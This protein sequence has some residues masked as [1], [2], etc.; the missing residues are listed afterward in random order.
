MP[1]LLLQSDDHRTV[2]DECHLD[3]DTVDDREGGARLLAR[4]GR[5]IRE[6]EHSRER[7]E[8]MARIGVVPPFTDYREL[9]G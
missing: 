7:G 8:R 5:V 4:L 6:A 3:L 2:L 9:G 1:H